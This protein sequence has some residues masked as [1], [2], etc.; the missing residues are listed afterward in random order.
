MFTV[1]IPSRG[2]QYTL[3][4]VTEVV[5]VDDTGVYVVLTGFCKTQLQC[6]SMIVFV[7]R[8]TVNKGSDSFTPVIDQKEAPDILGGLTLRWPIIAVPTV[9]MA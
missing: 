7:G 6:K 3:P 1:E 8:S 9:V 5:L 2:A 4:A